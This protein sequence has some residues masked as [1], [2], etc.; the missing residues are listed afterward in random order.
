MYDTGRGTHTSR[1]DDAKTPG[2]GH[3]R[4]PL[5]PQEKP[6]GKPSVLAAREESRRRPSADADGPQ[7]TPSKEDLWTAIR[8]TK[9][10][11]PDAYARQIENI[12]SKAPRLWR[13]AVDAATDQIRRDD[14]EAPLNPAAVEELA[15]LYVIHFRDGKWPAWLIGSL[16]PMLP[17]TGAA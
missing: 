12:R 11:K 7:S 6:A 10:Q 3:T 13:Q 1:G 8:T 15:Y 4:H 17:G 5:N 16:L 14:E 9:K 2:E